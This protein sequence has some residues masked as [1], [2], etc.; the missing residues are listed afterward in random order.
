MDKIKLV[1]KEQ[2]KEK[3]PDFKIG[4]N[5]RVHVKI[6]EGD[7]TRVQAFEGKVIARR[8]SGIRETFMVR[9]ISF[10]EGVERIFPL[11][12]PMLEK[13]EVVKAAAKPAKRAKLYHLRDKVG[14]L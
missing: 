7:K 4:D 5:V 2:L 6:T 9:R 14:K 1:E 13:V 10:G 8:G 11:H 3:V 12:S